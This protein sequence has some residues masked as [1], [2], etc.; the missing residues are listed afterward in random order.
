MNELPAGWQRTILCVVA[1]RITK[2]STPTSYGFSY[3]NKGIAFVKV[4]NLRN[5]S[6]N[7]HTI[8]HFISNDAD[9]N[10]KR[11]RLAAGDILFSIA[12]TIGATA[13]V[14]P[15]H[16]PANTN[17]ALAIIRGTSGVFEPRFLQ[18]QLQSQIAR[19]Q[20]NGVKR[21]GGMSNISLGD[22]EKFSVVVP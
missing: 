8:K 20:A 17:Q 19:E 5:G 2:G 9:E 22:L 12:G 6:I 7:T 10:Q 14:Q 11:S 21:G 1:Q 15:Q 18:Y 16:L 3:E 4:E 13:L